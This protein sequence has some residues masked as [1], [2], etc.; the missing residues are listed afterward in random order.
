MGYDVFISHSMR[1]KAIAD[2]LCDRLESTG[3]RCWM[4]PRDILPG[5]EWGEAIID[6]IK[7]SRIFLLVFSSHANTSKQV[8]REVERAAS[9]N[10][11]LLPVRVEDVE[12]SAALEYYISTPQWLDAITPPLERHLE[13]VVQIVGTLLERPEAAPERVAAVTPPSE[14]R[15]ALEAA[16][17]ARRTA[18]VEPAPLLA[19]PPGGRAIP[20]PRAGSTQASSDDED[21][22]TIHPYAPLVARI[23]GSLFLILGLMGATGFFDVA[24]AAALVYLPLGVWG[25]LA[26]FQA[27]RARTFN[28]SVAFVSAIVVVTGIF[29]FILEGR[30]LV[31][32]PWMLL[33]A[34]ATLVMGYFAFLHLKLP[35]NS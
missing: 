26:G 34:P 1:N 11:V 5:L 14:H 12:P 6:G 22:W 13:R 24:I 20:Q 23:A 25:M 29:T 10:M 9:R 32:F 3:M 8:L 35:A 18:R 21:K 4:A 33:H 2:A 17:A 7:Q 15:P 19:A 28:G 30:S 31:A 16:S 27:G